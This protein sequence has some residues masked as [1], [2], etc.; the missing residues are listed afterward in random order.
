[1]NVH[2]A[3]TRREK[4]VV[5]AVMAAILILVGLTRPLWL[6]SGSTAGSAAETAAEEVE[7]R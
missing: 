6:A 5:L 4:I 2:R 7:D 1:M 3:L